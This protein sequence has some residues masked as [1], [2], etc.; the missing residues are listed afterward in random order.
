MDWSKICAV[1]GP[2]G[3]NELAGLME[4]ATNGWNIAFM[5]PQKE[6]L[7]R[8]GQDLFEK[9]NIKILIV[10]EKEE[11]DNIEHDIEAFFYHGSWDDE[12][13][14]DIF[15]GFLEFK[16]GGVNFIIN[17]EVSK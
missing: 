15:W 6:I 2:A 9:H 12:E 10:N 17:G 14:V 13:D 11:Q 16:Y 4:F 7:E 8:V 5:D 1:N 3:D